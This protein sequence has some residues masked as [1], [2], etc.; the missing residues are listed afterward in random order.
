MD[1]LIA[2][3]QKLPGGGDMSAQALHISAAT[4]MAVLMF[5]VMALCAIVFKTL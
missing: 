1:A 4:T 3:F 5:T 2:L